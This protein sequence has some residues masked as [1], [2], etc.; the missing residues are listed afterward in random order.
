MYLANRMLGKS[1]DAGFV[2][3]SNFTEP[4]LAPGAEYLIQ[5]LA[6]SDFENH[7]VYKKYSHKRYLKASA[8]ARE[9]A[10]IQTSEE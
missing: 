5:E 10:K 3:Y 2:F 8:F 6:K 7:Y 1:W 9:W 4:Q